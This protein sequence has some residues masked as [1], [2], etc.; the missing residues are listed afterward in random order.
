MEALRHSEERFRALVE[1]VQDYAVVTLDPQ[2]RVTS[3]NSGAERTNG[4]C[5]EEILGQHFSRFFP[6]DDVARGLPERFNFG[7]DLSTVG[8]R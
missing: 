7:I 8:S 5:A 2:G 6:A 4:Y 1:G 3:W